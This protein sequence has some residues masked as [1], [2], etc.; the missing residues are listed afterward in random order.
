MKGMQGDEYDVLGD[1]HLLRHLAVYMGITINDS[2][3]SDK[4][5]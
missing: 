3:W 5:D 2:Y 1:F 4:I